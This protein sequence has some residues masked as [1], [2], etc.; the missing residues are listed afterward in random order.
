MEKLSSP[1]EKRV[2][3]NLK[4]LDIVQKFLPLSENSSHSLVS[5]AGYVPERSMREKEILLPKKRIFGTNAPS[6]QGRIQGGRSPTLKSES[7]CIHHGF[8]QFGK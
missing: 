2:G 7:N 1:L 6:K 3:E 5:R 8:V 4:L